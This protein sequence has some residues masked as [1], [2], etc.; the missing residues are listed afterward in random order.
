MLFSKNHRQILV[1]AMIE[2]LVRG[3]V[4][5][6]ALLGVACRDSRS[7]ALEQLIRLALLR[8]ALLSTLLE[9]HEQSEALVNE[10]GRQLDHFLAQQAAQIVQ[11]LHLAVVA[12]CA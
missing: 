6:H 11:C 3:S 10:L 7:Q 9:A 5:I 4:P 1:Q 2:E 8:P 12:C